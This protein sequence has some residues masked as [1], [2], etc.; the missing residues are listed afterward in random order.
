MKEKKDIR[1]DIK[2]KRQSHLSSPVGNDTEFHLRIKEIGCDPVVGDNYYVCF[3]VT[4]ASK[5]DD[6]GLP[7]ARFVQM[8]KPHVEEVTKPHKNDKDAKL[9]NLIKDM[10]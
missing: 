10:Y 6:S 3:P 9:K 2:G 1:D 5:G 7:M 4:C 8:G